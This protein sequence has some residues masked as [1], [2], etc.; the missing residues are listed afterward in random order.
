MVVQEDD[1]SVGIDTDFTNDFE[2]LDISSGGDLA[3]GGSGAAGGPQTL[4]DVELENEI[5]EGMD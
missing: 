1:Q 3:S 2:G 4:A 5:E